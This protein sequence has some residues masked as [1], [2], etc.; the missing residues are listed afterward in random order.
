MPKKDVF[1]SKLKNT[2]PVNFREFYNF[3]FDWLSNETNLIVAEDKYNEKNSGDSKGIEAAWTAFRKITDYFKFQV[4]VIW[5]VTGLRNIEYEKGGK[6]IKTNFG[7]V[8]IKVTGTLIK[9]YEG[10]FQNSPFNTFLNKIYE[11][12]LIKARIEH[13]EDKLMADCDEFLDQAKA[14]LATEAQKAGIIEV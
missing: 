12:V 2:G 7:S 5:R 8:Q 10:K 3:C 14:F 11:K 13:Y 6:K 4:K 1:E 9:D